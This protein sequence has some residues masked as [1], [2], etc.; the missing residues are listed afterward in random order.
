MR[1]ILRA[2]LALTVGAALC[3]TAACGGGGDGGGRPSTDEIAK[4]LKSKASDNPFA[5]LVDKIDDQTANCIAEKLHSS[6]I[7]DKA[8]RALVKGDTDY[9]GSTS[10]QKAAAELVPALT[11]C[12]KK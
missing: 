12:A 5:G 6:E 11:S 3:G 9:K 7:S 2:V 8:L 1:T 4:T 10:D